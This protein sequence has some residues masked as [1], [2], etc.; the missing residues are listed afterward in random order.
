MANAVIEEGT[1]VETLT[2]EIEQT[3]M[4]PMGDVTIT[5]VSTINLK[6]GDQNAELDTPQGKVE[7]V[8]EDGEGYQIIGGQQFPL[9]DAQLAQ[10]ETESERNYVYIA[11]NKD[12]LE[13]EYIG[14]ET[15][16]DTGHAVVEVELSAPVTYYIN[17]QSN[18]PTKITYSQFNQQTGQEIDVEV[19]YSDW[20]TVSGVTYA[21]S[22]ESFANGQPA[23]VGK[24]TDLSVNQ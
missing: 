18:L 3:I 24:V 20:Q 15:I 12:T 5:G 14:M 11:L 9:N 2:T 17:T 4:S 1:D 22:I 13:A 7:V 19:Q 23:S 10:I 21:F 6:T 16:D 8:I